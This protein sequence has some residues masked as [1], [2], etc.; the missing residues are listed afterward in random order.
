V[1][2]RAGYDVYRDSFNTPAFFDMLPEVAGQRGLDVGCGEGHNTRL[3]AARGAH[4][5]ALDI[6]PTF[7]RYAAA[8]AAKRGLAINHTVGSGPDLPFVSERFDFVTGFMSFMDIPE[9][10]ALLREAYRVLAP[11]GFLQFSISHP[12]FDAPY[13]RHLRDERGSTYA[14]EVGGY[15]EGRQGEVAEWVFSA[16]PPEAAVGLAPLRT[17][18]FT[19]T[20]GGWLNGLIDAGFT[21][22][23]VA[24][25]RPSDA[26]VARWPDVQDAQVV[27]YFL[28]VRARRPGRIALGSHSAQV[29]ASRADSEGSGCRA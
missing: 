8:A 11:G 18:R 7:V 24:E 23:R 29:G 2:S 22:E 1:L 15:F 14:F 5:T 16:A 17:P 4:V 6:S 10:D 28:H 13:R 19:R 21:I 25:P 20:L 26:I 9:T 3:L 12:C 27:A